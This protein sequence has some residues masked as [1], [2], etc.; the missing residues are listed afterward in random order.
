MPSA[1]YATDPKEFDGLIVPT[2]RRVF[3]RAPDEHPV[4]ERIAVAIDLEAVRG[5]RSRTVA[6]TIVAL[7]NDAVC[8]EP[9]Q[10][11]GG[12]EAHWAGP[13]D[14]HLGMFVAHR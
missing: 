6:D 5:L 11:D 12:R 4:R 8:A 14:Q 13:D 1:N 3:V 7:D 2:K 10:F 9:P